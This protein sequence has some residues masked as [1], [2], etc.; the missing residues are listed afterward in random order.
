MRSEYLLSS[1]DFFAFLI[2]TVFA[3]FFI[4]YI[5]I[6]WIKNHFIFQ[7]FIV[8]FILR[9]LAVFGSAYFNLYLNKA[10]SYA[11][12]T[13]AKAISNAMH[14]LDFNEYSKIFYIDFDNLPFKTKS[15]FTNSEMINAIYDENKT[16]VHLA[17]I[18][19]FFCFDSYLAISFFF[20]LWGYI[21]I[22]LIFHTV[23]KKYTSTLKYCFFFIIAYPSLFYWTTGVLK[24]PLCIG[25]IGVLFYVFFN[26]KQN[27]ER[28]YFFLF[29]GVLAAFILIK[30]KSYLFYCFF[31]SLLIAY[32]IPLLRRLYS[33]IPK[34][35]FIFILTLLGFI[36]YYNYYYIQN[37]VFSFFIEETIE[38]L[39]TA[40]QWQLS[41]GGSSYDIGQVDLNVW[42]M[43]K[44]LFNSFNVAL[45][46]PY[47][48]ESRSLQV[49]VF[50]IESFISILMVLYAFYNKSVRKVFRLIFSNPLLSFSL[51]FVI[52]LAILTGGISF[53]FGTLVRY[54]MPLIPFFYSLFFIIITHKESDRINRNKFFR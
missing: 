4:K 22:W 15:F 51:F 40:T 16:I 49:L 37:A 32:A 48:W 47:P 52:F 7:I 23:T 45:F 30:V 41:E 8:G 12:F 20:S 39:S 6:H 35:I 9:L 44:Y 21:G 26:N 43:V 25:S 13:A 18:I 11:Y 33:L 14:R 24:E 54:K 19:S 42:S 46:R 5:S 17:A 2:C 31:S 28:R 38:N 50:S 1:N 34:Y 10:D 29:L 3:F 53:N 27:Q 36:I